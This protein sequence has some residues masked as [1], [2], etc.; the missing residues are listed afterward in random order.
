[1]AEHPPNVPVEPGRSG[2]RAILATLSSALVVLGGYLGFFNEGQKTWNSVFGH[3]RAPPTKVPAATTRIVVQKLSTGGLTFGQYL[4][5]LSEPRSGFSRARLRER[6]LF[7]VAR[8]RLVGYRGRTLPVEWHVFDAASKDQV[9]LLRS[10]ARADSSDDTA[11]E[12]RWFHPRQTGHR[13]YL[14]Y[15]IY[16]DRGSTQQEIA[17][18]Q[19]ETS[20]RI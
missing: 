11:T 8:V 5:H 4:D 18:K 14:E 17:R 9:T 16:S 10:T 19:S 3:D 6:G 7:M 20:A 12:P 2:R 15:V 1:M 13:Y